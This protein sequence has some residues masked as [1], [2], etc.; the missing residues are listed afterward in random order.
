LAARQNI[1]KRQ[2]RTFLLKFPSEI[3]HVY[4]HR[5]SKSSL[6]CHAAWDGSTAAAIP[7]NNL[8][9]LVDDLS[10]SD[11]G[12]HGGFVIATIR[13]ALMKATRSNCLAKNRYA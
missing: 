8:I 10:W 1:P 12:F 5:P 11:V 6:V 9:F 4:P 2:E 7:P 3:A 13:S